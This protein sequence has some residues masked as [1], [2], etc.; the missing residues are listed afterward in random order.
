MQRIKW[1]FL[2]FS[3]SASTSCLAIRVAVVGG[4]ISGSFFVK[5]LS[6]YDEG[7]CA[8]TKVTIFD[9]FPMGE[10]TTTTQD[11]WQGSRVSSTILSD[12][13]VVELG[14]S[15][16]YS[17]F[18]LFVDMVMGD[19]S[20]E[21]GEAF[22]TGQEKR[23]PEGL[24]TGLGIYGGSGV[25]HLLTAN[26][27]STFNN[28]KMFWRYNIDFFRMMFATKRVE[29]SFALMYQ[30]LDS[31]HTST[32]FNSPDEM[33]KDAGLIKPTH[34]SFDAFLDSI[35][36]Q[37]QL[38]W[39]RKYLPY[40]GLLRDELLTAI[41]LCNYNQANS[42]VN[43]LVG[44]GS[45]VSLKAALLSIVGGNQ[46]VI[47]SALQQSQTNHKR[48]CKK[49]VI[50]QSQ[51][52]V[53]AVIADLNTMELFSNEQSLGEFDVV[54]LAAPMQQARINFFVRSTVDNAV[55]LPMPFHLIDA[56][57]PEDTGD[58]HP[59][60]PHSLPDVATRPYTQV[61]TTVVSH[62]DLNATRF[63]LENN[64]L[65]R[66]IYT[67]EA[68]KAAES[69]ITAISQITPDGV[70]KIFSSNRLSDSD[71]QELFGTNHTVEFTKVWG[72]QHGGATP[73]YRGQGMSMDYL[74]FDA[75][76][77]LKGTKQEGSALYYVN[78]IEGS[79]ACME[80]SAIG[81]KS[82]AKLV[83]RRLGIVQ[84][85]ENGEDDGKNEL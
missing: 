30:V 44:L 14:A 74:L 13:S 38:N 40:Q 51:S 42:Q 17:G 11:D 3:S 70:Y 19:P 75:G 62:G 25:W 27:T 49:N 23:R 67:T 69:N 79:M 43:G 10:T 4:G 31:T 32:F 21:M 65:P 82:V 1:L 50:T 22:N 12:G 61:V 29:R 34:S 8:L 7:S 77:G 81:A 66:G 59:L 53:T 57:N 6:D 72:G 18:Q 85:W 39:W 9:P 33:W 78:A 24:R 46:K 52:R 83:A 58:G 5:Y 80:L 76:V 64:E 55:I 84:S 63:G 20:L 60:M 41:N 68:G 48:F 54:V 73:D 71:L 16:F 36:L 47:K 45:F 2:L 28:L 35:G 15:V 56:E 26:S 37:R